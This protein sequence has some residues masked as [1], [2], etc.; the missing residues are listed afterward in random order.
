MKKEYEE[1]VA[2]EFLKCV[3]D[4]I[5]RLDNAETHRPFHAALLS[6]DALFWS[7]FER[8]FSTSFGQRVIEQISRIAALAGGATD[9]ANQKDTNVTLS[10]I[11]FSA[12]ESHIS[13]IREGR[14]GRAPNWNSDLSAV[15]VDSVNGNPVTTRVRSDL[16]W[17]KNG[18]NHYMSIKTV[19]P[20]I[21]QTAEAKRDLLKLKLYDPNCQVYF[22]LYYNPYGEHRQD[23]MWNPP[24]GVFDFNNDPVVLIGKEYWDNLGGVGFYEEV[25]TIAEEV[26]V[27]TKLLV[28]QLNK[29][30]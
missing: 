5:T 22:G 10:D 23:Y 19:K 13:S 15:T 17:V 14:L 20:N 6:D 9:A 25:L 21:D 18:I 29:K 2:N 1:I 8:S 16:W 24:K 11:Q 26:G 7:R 12:I 4:T 27:K 3:K 28:G 30:N